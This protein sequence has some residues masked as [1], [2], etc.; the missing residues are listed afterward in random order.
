M[1]CYI[2]AQVEGHTAVKPTYF[3][4]SGVYNYHCVVGSIGL[5][6]ILQGNDV[7]REAI[8]A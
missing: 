3:S 5:V 1:R 4:I 8:D 6:K 2:S 7:S